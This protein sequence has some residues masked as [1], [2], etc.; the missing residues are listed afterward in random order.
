MPDLPH[1]G[2]DSVVRIQEDAFAPDLLE[3]FLARHQLPAPV[4]KYEE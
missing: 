3:D 2:I 4:G 1:R